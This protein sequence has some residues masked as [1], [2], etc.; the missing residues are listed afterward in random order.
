M[1]ESPTRYNVGAASAT[2]IEAKM[3]ANAVAMY[4]ILTVEEWASSCLSSEV[5]S[6]SK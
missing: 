2:V 6:S 5:C 4:F 1:V 3:N